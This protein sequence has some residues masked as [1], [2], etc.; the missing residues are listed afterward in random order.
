MQQNIRIQR[1]VVN[2]IVQSTERDFLSFMDSYINFTCQWAC[3]SKH[4]SVY[5][6]LW[7]T[8]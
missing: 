2:Y 6:N 7:N 4:C 5:R 1:R 8:F 3:E